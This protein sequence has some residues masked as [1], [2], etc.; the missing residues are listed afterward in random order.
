[1]SEPKIQMSNTETEA[2]REKRTEQQVLNIKSP[3]MGVYKV[4]QIN[5]RKQ[6]EKKRLRANDKRI[7]NAR[8]ATGANSTDD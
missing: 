3:S 8:T 4:K 7:L 1:M 2:E 6:V 5:A